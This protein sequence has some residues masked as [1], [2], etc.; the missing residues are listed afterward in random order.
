MQFITQGKTNWKYIL[1]VVIFALFVGGIVFGYWT[2]VLKKEISF[3]SLGIKGSKGINQEILS[4]C[5]K[6]KGDLCAEYENC[7][8]PIINLTE[9]D[10]C[11]SQTCSGPTQ[12]E[13]S[14]KKH[15]GKNPETGKFNYCYCEPNK[16]KNKV[17]VVYTKGRIY[18]SDIINFQILEYYKAV[19]KDLNIENAGLK[20]FDGKTMDELDKFIDN[21]YLNDNVG[22]IILVGDDL[23]V[24]NITKDSMVNLHAISDKLECINKD[25]R[26]CKNNDCRLLSC[27]DVAISYILPPVLYSDNEKVEFVFNIFKTYTNY[28]ENFAAVGNEYRKSVLHIQDPEG[29]TGSPLLGYSLPIVAIQN[30]E[31]KKVS[32]ELKKKYAVL[33]LGVH[34][35]T[36]VVGIGIG[37]QYTTLQEYSAFAKENG[38]PA[39]FVDSGACQAIAIKDVETGLTRYCC[40]PQIFMEGGAW[41]YYAI[42]SS[43]GTLK[44]FSRGETVGFSI[45]N[46]VVD[47]HF[48]FGD[49]LAHL[50]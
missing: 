39:L 2:L 47:Q 49:I 18:D 40:W 9:T 46:T 31:T 10:R 41:V 44:G 16:L 37:G 4:V 33:S 17:A 1:V 32:D 29:F 12:F 48:I 36:N 23:P 35:T 27:N 14:S 8:H 43:Y 3:E 7:D 42:G 28:H 6:A 34:G 13:F 22:Y 24:S 5:E 45:R 21:L 38:T 26:E 15:C 50:K 20:K 30:T 19:K 11:C 25:C